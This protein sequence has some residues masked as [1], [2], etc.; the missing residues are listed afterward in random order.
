MTTEPELGDRLNGVRRNLGKSMKER[1]SL[2]EYMVSNKEWWRY[3]CKRI[4][5]DEEAVPYLWDRY[6]GLLSLAASPRETSSRGT[7]RA[8]PS[9]NN[10]GRKSRL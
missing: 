10:I 1:W 9:F 2:E 5:G 3:C 4:T 6:G 8:L 7:G